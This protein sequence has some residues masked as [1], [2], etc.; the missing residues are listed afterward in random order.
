LVARFISKE[1]QAKEQKLKWKFRLIKKYV[2]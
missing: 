2:T 1:L